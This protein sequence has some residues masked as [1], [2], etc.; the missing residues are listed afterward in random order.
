MFLGKPVVVK[1]RSRGASGVYRWVPDKFSDR[2]DSDDDK[3]VE[4]AGGIP[5]KEATD[6]SSAE[7]QAMVDEHSGRRMD[8]P[9]KRI[10]PR[11]KNTVFEDSVS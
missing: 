11:E 10:Q 7:M 8:D 1:R 6:L 2:S 5:A 4:A 3:V 9:A